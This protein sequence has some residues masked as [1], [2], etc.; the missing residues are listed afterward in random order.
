VILRATQTDPVRRY[1]NAQSFA[2]SLAEAQA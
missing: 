1:P 2:N